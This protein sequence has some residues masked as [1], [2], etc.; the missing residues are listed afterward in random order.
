MKVTIKKKG[1]EYNKKAHTFIKLLEE[2][3]RVCN[4][5]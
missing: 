3:E 2:T 5:A 4:S 1:K